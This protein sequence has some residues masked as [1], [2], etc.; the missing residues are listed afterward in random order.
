MASLDDLL[1]VAVQAAARGAELMRTRE[2]GRLAGKGDR[3]YASEV[4]LAVERD[5]RTFLAERTPHIGF[6]GE[7]EGTSGAAT[8]GEQWV[9]DPIDG[10]VNFAH[11]VPLCGV[12]LALVRD[13][14][15]VVGVVELPLLAARY[16]AT[17]GGGAWRDG[18]PIRI[19]GAARLSDALANLGDYGVGAGS[20]ERNAVRFA[21]TRQVAHRALRVRMLG[22]AA[23]DLVWVADGRT[24]VSITLSNKPWDMAAG[25]L[26][27]REAGAAVVD[28]DG[29]PHTLDSSATI[30]A[31]PPLLDEVL[32]MVAAAVAEAGAAAQ[33]GGAVPESGAVAPGA[34]LL[35]PRDDQ[36]P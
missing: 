5:L 7:E 10:T 31:P 4:D 2:P 33:A 34:G 35:T 24:D 23:I 21:L 28:V 12:S 14:R 9:L 36:V 20:G 17:A 22:S 30:A 6:L 32:T 26:I 18:E 27:A 25:T 16:T 11:G 3:D 29:T 15:P 1:A 8:D 19:R 13:R